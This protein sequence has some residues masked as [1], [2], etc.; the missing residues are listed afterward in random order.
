MTTVTATKS[1]LKTIDKYGFDRAAFDANMADY[2]YTTRTVKGGIEI[3]D[4]NH[5]FVDF[6]E[7]VIITHNSERYGFAML[8]EMENTF[9]CDG[10]QFSTVFDE[11][12]Y[13][14]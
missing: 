14:R 1:T 11:I 5:E 6:A 4:E 8:G 13:Y 12:E 9:N 2:G 10:E 3:L 7:A